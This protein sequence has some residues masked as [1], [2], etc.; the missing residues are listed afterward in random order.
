MLNVGSTLTFLIN[1]C[2]QQTVQN[3]KLQDFYIWHF[4]HLCLI[5]LK[6]FIFTVVSLTCIVFLLY[7]N[8][9]VVKMSNNCKV[10]VAENIN[11]IL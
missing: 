11:M 1:Q 2:E 3:L 7:L 9:Q 6:H 8:F 5:N 4:L 10:T